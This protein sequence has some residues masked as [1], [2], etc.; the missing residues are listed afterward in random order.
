MRQLYQG[1]A[2]IATALTLASGCKIIPTVRPWDEKELVDRILNEENARKVC[3]KDQKGT[4]YE[5]SREREGVAY[6]VDHTN[7]TGVI[8]YDKDNNGLGGDG[9][10][11]SITIRVGYS[12]Q[13]I[14]G[15][16]TGEGGFNSVPYHIARDIDKLRKDSKNK[17]KP[18]VL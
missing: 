15:K 14:V 5:V 1:I 17:C 2:T 4:K 13:E 10:R 9:D 16:A 6:S 11:V 18:T 3:F 7:G 8:I 12:A